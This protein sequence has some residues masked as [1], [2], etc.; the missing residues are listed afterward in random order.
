MKLSTVNGDVYSVLFKHLSL[1]ALHWKLFINVCNNIKIVVK[2]LNYCMLFY[3]LFAKKILRIRKKTPTMTNNQNGV[4][5]QPHWTGIS[6][7]LYLC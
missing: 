6:G 1:I 3:L 4:D 2:L 7:S 5:F